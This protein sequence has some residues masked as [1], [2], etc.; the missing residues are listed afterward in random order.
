[1]TPKSLNELWCIDV[2]SKPIFSPFWCIYNVQ[3]NYVQMLRRWK[4]ISMCIM[5]TLL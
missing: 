3:K 1:M 2:V 4:C 5:N